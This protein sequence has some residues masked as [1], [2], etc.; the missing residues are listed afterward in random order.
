MIR[1]FYAP[2][3]MVDAAADIRCMPVLR[4]SIQFIRI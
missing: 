2:T 3:P 4:S 1:Y